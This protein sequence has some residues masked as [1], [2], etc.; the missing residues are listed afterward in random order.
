[1]AE[2]YRERGVVS[3]SE[4]LEKI[5]AKPAGQYLREAMLAPS[6]YSEPMV[7]QALNE[8][9]DRVRE[10]KLNDSIIKARQHGD[11]ESLNQI[12]KLRKVKDQPS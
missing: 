11:L 2:L 5:E 1:M 7:E 12:L 9:E 10:K 4:L 6:I 8:F 3:A